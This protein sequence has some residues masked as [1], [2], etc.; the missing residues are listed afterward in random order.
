[1]KFSTCLG[2]SCGQNSS[3]ISPPFSIVM[4]AVGAFFAAGAAGAGA[5][6]VATPNVNTNALTSAIENRI[7]ASPPE[8][9]NVA[10]IITA[11]HDGDMRGGPWYGLRWYRLL[12]LLGGGVRVWE[13]PDAHARDRP[14]PERAN[15]ACALSFQSQ[16]RAACGRFGIVLLS[17]PSG[18]LAIHPT[19]RAARNRP[20]TAPNTSLSIVAMLAAW[21]QPGSS[22]AAS[23]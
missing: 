1:M 19:T 7:I 3:T 15:V 8:A 18:L 16:R 17:V 2:A 21:I 5:W 23:G 13:I 11:R 6:A 20:E 9:R 12:R 10:V 22:V 14:P 4:T